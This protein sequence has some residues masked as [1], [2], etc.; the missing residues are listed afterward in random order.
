[1]IGKMMMQHKQNVSNVGEMQHKKMF[2]LFEESGI[3]VATCHH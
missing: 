3:F 2:A 1:M